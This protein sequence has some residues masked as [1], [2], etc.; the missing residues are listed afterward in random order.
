MA[1]LKR[2]GRKLT[3]S[4]KAGSNKM[5]SVVIRP[6]ALHDLAEIWAYIAEDSSRQANLFAAAL[7]A[8]F[9]SLHGIP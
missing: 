4:R 9:D 1:E 5:S 8:S 3:A 7:I 2:Q 6:K